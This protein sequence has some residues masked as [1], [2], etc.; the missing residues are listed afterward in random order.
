MRLRQDRRGAWG[1]FYQ[2]H[3][4]QFADMSGLTEIKVA[5]TGISS[6]LG[7]ANPFSREAVRARTIKA[8]SDRLRSEGAG[9]LLIVQEHAVGQSIQEIHEVDL[10]LR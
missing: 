10:V 1:R 5:S 3:G 7:G 8:L 9:E 2:G 6:S 4:V